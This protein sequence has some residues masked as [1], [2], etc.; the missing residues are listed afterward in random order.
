MAK[1]DVPRVLLDSSALI[2]VIKG[3]PNSEHVDG[4]LNMLDRKEVQLVESVIVLG[5][6]FKLSDHKDQ[7]VRA[8]YDA[9]LH[10]IRSLLESRE[11]LLLDVTKPIVQ[12]A[13]RYRRD[14]GMR[15]PD[16]VH[17][18]TAVLNRCDWLVTYDRDFSQH[19]DGVRVVQLNHVG[20][21][22][23]LPWQRHVEEGLFPYP[24]GD[25]F[26]QMP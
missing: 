16:A 2:A 5:E 4:L 24:V 18:A 3:E 6:V 23:D 20:E 12:K 22:R 1:T 17:L 19:L 25:S 21:P 26:I 14:H 13:T 8:R 7:A 11:V 15:L 9:E 10:K